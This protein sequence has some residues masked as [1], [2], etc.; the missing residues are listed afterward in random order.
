MSQMSPEMSDT[1]KSNCQFR[2]TP[3]QI[4]GSNFTFIN[5]TAS[6]Q[7]LRNVLQSLVGGLYG[8]T[9]GSKLKELHAATYLV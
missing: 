5:I 4:L 6:A 2:S 1:Q 8:Y 3:P 7:W 9:N